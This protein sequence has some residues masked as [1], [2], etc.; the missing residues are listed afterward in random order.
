MVTANNWGA[1]GWGSNGCSA[2]AHG[3]GANRCA[4]NSCRGSKLLELTSVVWM[5]GANWHQ[6]YVVAAS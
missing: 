5:D 1:N 6:I 4:S 2:N 3:C